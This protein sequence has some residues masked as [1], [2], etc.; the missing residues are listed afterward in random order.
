MR[1]VQPRWSV[2]PLTARGNLI[3]PLLSKQNF[4]PDGKEIF[5]KMVSIFSNGRVRYIFTTLCSYL[6]PYKSLVSGMAIATKSLKKMFAGQIIG[7]V[8][9]FFR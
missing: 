6:A 3:L 7:D 1:S 5:R 2:Q 9:Y 4:Q 8:V